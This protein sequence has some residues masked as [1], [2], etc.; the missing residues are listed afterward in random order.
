MSS[1]CSRE[2]DPSAAVSTFE[3]DMPRNCGCRLTFV[4]MTTESRLPRARVHS[5]MI[6]SDSPPAFPGTQAEYESA[7]SMWLPPP[8]TKASSTANDV[9]LS[10]VQ[11]KVLPPS[12]SGNTSRS[13]LPITVIRQ[14]FIRTWAAPSGGVPAFPDRLADLDARPAAQ[15]RV[16]VDTD[17]Q[18]GHPHH[19]GRGDRRGH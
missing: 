11:P 9:S 12:P 14:D 2:S 5:P 7:G 17:R 19:P 18:P 4:A 1:F 8:A 6:V 10:D 3:R 15:D 16:G 13:E